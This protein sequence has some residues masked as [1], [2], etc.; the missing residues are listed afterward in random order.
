MLSE[1]PSHCNELQWAKS[2]DIQTASVVSKWPAA[3]TRAIREVDKTLILQWFALAI[4][5]SINT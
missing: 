2:L 3:H 1:L 4:T 5:H